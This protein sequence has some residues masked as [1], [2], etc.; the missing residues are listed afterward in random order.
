M[1]GTH[2]KHMGVGEVMTVDSLDTLSRFDW[3]RL[4]AELSRGMEIS[5]RDELS[6]NA[7]SDI[8]FSSAVD[9]A[10]SERLNRRLSASVMIHAPSRFTVAVATQLVAGG[11]PQIQ[12]SAAEMVAAED[13]GGYVLTRADVGLPLRV[14]ALSHAR[15]IDPNVT[16]Y[17]CD[18]SSPAPLSA[19][20]SLTIVYADRPD[21][22]ARMRMLA[23]EPAMV[24]PVIRSGSL[25]L[26]GPVASA[27]TQPCV[28]CVCLAFEEGTEAAPGRELPFAAENVVASIAAESALRWLDEGSAEAAPAATGWVCDAGLMSVERT[29]IRPSLDCGCHL[30]CVQE[31]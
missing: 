7:G 30:Q 11:V 16:V 18:A 21:F 5:D 25:T 20:N 17:F 10:L 15:A 24:L 19:Q 23:P 6:V 12:L 26:I 27:L 13:L 9:R 4:S 2:R 22:L 29:L 31:R 1:L 3:Q 8:E 14:V 28:E